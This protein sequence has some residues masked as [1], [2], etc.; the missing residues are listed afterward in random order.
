MTWNSG[1]CAHR[2]LSRKKSAAKEILK[3]TKSNKYYG[4]FV[5]IK[6]TCIDLE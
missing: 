6:I 4:I 5:K 3:L 2:F 1:V